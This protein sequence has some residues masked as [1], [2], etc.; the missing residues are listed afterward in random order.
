V[1]KQHTATADGTSNGSFALTTTGT[2]TYNYNDLVTFTVTI[3]SGYIFD[4]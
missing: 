1:K 3:P 4:G 2:A